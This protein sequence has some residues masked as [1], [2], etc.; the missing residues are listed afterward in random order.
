MLSNQAEEQLLQRVGAAQARQNTLS[1]SS[2]SSVTFS[3]GREVEKVHNRLKEHLYSDTGLIEQELLNELKNS[4]VKFNLE[5]VVMIARGPEGH[6][7]WLEKGN[8]KAGLDH[9]LERHGNDFEKK[10]VSHIPQLIKKL[11]SGTPINSGRSKK[12][13]YADYIFEGTTYR[14]AYGTNGFIVSVYPID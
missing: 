5:D 6:L 7:L 3:Q 12:G 10:K 4:G 9:V 11:L 14:I 1:S 2:G 8:S 13:F